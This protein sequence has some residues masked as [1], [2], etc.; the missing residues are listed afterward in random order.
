MRNIFLDL[1][2]D[3]MQKDSF[4]QKQYFEQMID[5]KSNHHRE[6]LYFAVWK[7]ASARELGSEAAANTAVF[8]LQ[9]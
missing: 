4:K 8:L 2:P 3:F 7:Q 1:T 6:Y 9:I 5:L